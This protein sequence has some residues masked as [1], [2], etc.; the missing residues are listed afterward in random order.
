MERIEI[1]LQVIQGEMW[2]L[3]NKLLS[4]VHGAE[5]EFCNFHVMVI[6]QKDWIKLAWKQSN[7]NLMNT[8]FAWGVY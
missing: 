3:V 8:S 5:F 1:M 6:A 2:H 7:G 4:M